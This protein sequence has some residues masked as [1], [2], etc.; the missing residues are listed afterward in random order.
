MFCHPE[1][2]VIHESYEASKADISFGIQNG[3]GF[4]SPERDRS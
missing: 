3:Q 1:P 2:T 4:G